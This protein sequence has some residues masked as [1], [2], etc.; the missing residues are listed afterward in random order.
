MLVVSPVAVRGWAQSAD[1][2][3]QWMVMVAG[4]YR[5]G[6]CSGK[7]GRLLLRTQ[8]VIARNE[9][10]WQSRWCSD[11]PDPNEIAELRSQ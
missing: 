10:T 5:P 3:Q 8:A 9:V 6:G 4:W 11:D 1:F 7:A 2:A